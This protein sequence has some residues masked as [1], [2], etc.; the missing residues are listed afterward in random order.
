MPSRRVTAA[1]VLATAFACAA[2]HLL[3]VY[4]AYRAAPPG[5]EFTG[6]LRSAN[7]DIMQ[8]RVWYRQ[9]QRQGPIVNSVFTTEPNDPH[10]L[11]LLPWSIGQAAR[12]TGIPP[13]FVYEY[14]GAIF[15]F[16]LVLLIWVAVCR[17]FTV[18]YQRWVVFPA[19]LIGGGLGG[20]LKLLL[21]FESINS[22]PVIKSTLTDAVATHPLFEDYRGHFVF[23][24]FFDSH[25]ALNWALTLA[26]ILALHSWLRH[27]HYARLI[28]M[29]AMFGVL[30]VL[31]FHEGPILVVIAAV[32]AV[33]CW[34]KGIHV[35][36]AVV[37]FVAGAATVGIVFVW[38]FVLARR[39][40][41]PLMIE[42]SEPIAVA[43]L[44]LAYPLQWVLGV[45]GLRRALQTHSIDAVFLCAWAIGCTILTLA[46]PFY[47]YPDRG[48]VTLPIAITLLAGYAY[49][50]HRH[51]L[52]PVALAAAVF[53]LAVTPS[54]FMTRLVVNGGF[55]SDIPAV[56]LGPGNQEILR[57]LQTRAMAE[58]VLLARQPQ[59]LWLAP[60]YIGRSYSGHFV[61]TAD[62]D[63]K[64][65]EVERFFQLDAEAQGA[66]LKDK[67]I[68]LVFSEP[69]DQSRMQ[70][71]PALRQVA[72]SAAG[73]LF[74]VATR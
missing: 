66:F 46:G 60:D 36:R 53:F 7:P 43:I 25:F 63:R 70:G 16:A 28:A 41:L 61:L 2:L 6:N 64:N 68:T 50:T 57:A 55:R 71:N 62:F 17:W 10:V 31:H 27:G 13:E 20:H 12:L 38:H 58:D 8:Y 65:A 40:G 51:R 9:T 14:A 21:R 30:T 73:T 47:P 49:F 69:G 29:L 3:P 1:A 74:E 18:S 59:L 26:A 15:T 72:T 37:A 52:T 67:G 54:W 44:F 35:Q 5:W 48:T 24:T 23:T 22:L 19:I 39:S 33:L 56:F 45:L 4:L 34:Q 11:V 32:A 42:S